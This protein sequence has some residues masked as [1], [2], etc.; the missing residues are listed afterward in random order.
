MTKILVIEDEGSLREEI[1]DWLTYEHFEVTGADDGI[2]GIEQAFHNVPDL[3]ICDITMPRLD[4]FGV[5]LELRSN[6]KTAGVPFIFV[7]A[8]AAHDDI[9]RGMSLGADDY[10]TK[11]FLRQELLGAVQARLGKKA[12]QEQTLLDEID[13]LEIALEQEREQRLLKVKL[14]AMLSHDFRTPLTTIVSSADLV[15]NYADRLDDERRIK[16]MNRIKSSAHLLEQMLDDMLIIARMETGNLVF[17]P[18]PLAVEP[19]FQRMVEEFQMLYQETHQI[20]FE[21]H[22]DGTILADPR[23]LRQ[24]GSNLISNAIKYSLQG[25]E[26]RVILDNKQGQ[27]ILMVQDQGI[28]ISE[29]DQTRLF[30]AFQRGSNVGNISGTGLGLAIVAQAVD[31]HGGSVRVESEVGS[32]TTIIVSIPIQANQE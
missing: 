6:T 19:Y 32:G 25:S 24:V 15:S 29:G 21:S 26:V 17:N 10:L 11:P 4:G 28:G 12:A 20:L 13:Q 23:L 31:L 2:S 22:F 5:L 3:I 30:S 1:M 27:C 7:T 8:R 16:H 14:I 18:E 9:R